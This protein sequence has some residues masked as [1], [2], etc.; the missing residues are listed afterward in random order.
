M[1]NSRNRLDHRQL[2][3][4]EPFSAESPLGDRV[5]Q[6]RSPNGIAYASMPHLIPRM[7]SASSMLTETKPRRM[8]PDSMTDG[9]SKA[10]HAVQDDRART[11]RE[12]PAMVRRAQIQQFLDFDREPLRGDVA[13]ESSG[14]DRATS[15]V[16]AGLGTASAFERGDGDRSS[17]ARAIPA[18]RTGDGRRGSLF[19]GRGD[20]LPET[21]HATH[22]KSSRKRVY[23]DAYRPLFDL[24]E[25]PLHPP[26]AEAKTPAARIARSLDTKV[27]S[28]E[29]AKA[30]DILA[31]IR[32]LQ[33]VEAEQRLPTIDERET[34]LRFGGFG[35]VALSLFPDPITGHYKDASW[36]TLGE[37]LEESLNP[38][39]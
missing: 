20:G 30:R 6:K 23:E 31:A 9:Q 24:R 7:E 14:T 26:P 13:G 27:A 15:P 4:F 12:S 36:Q 11:D 28:G 2:S 37:E 22:L 39:P 32:T 34:L 3:L 25:E 5:M 19:A 29:K 38:W 1:T 18:D 8:P 16:T 17:A 35:P 10:S 33:S 21:A